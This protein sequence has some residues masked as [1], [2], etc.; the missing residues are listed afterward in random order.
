MHLEPQ[1]SKALTPEPPRPCAHARY[2]VAFTSDLVDD[3]PLA[4]TLLGQPLV[5]W[6][7]SISGE[8]RCTADKCP[9]RLAPLSEVH[10]TPPHPAHPARRS[11]R[12]N[13]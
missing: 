3:A 4:F 8:Y 5:F 7:D 9:H 12:P 11:L 10:P 13:P 1:P 2:P 6:K